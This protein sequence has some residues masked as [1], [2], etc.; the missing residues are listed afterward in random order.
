M[1]EKREQINPK[2]T[3]ATKALL[4]Q[5]CQERHTT[6]SDVVEAALLAFMQPSAHDE[7]R[8]VVL[9]LLRGI[10]AKQDVLHAGV[11]ALLPLLTSMVERLEDKSPEAPEPVVPIARYDQLYEAF[12]APEAPTA[13]TSSAP[14]ETPEDAP[15]KARRLFGWK[16]SS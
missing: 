7:V 10:D 9:E 1:P 8:E 6:Q 5:Y 16:L 13:P 11:Q 4:M 14:M 2:V 3:P 12:R 15:S